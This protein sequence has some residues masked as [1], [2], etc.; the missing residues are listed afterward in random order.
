MTTKLTKQEFLALIANALPD[1]E[2]KQHII[3]EATRLIPSEFQRSQLAAIHNCRSIQRASAAYRALN[4]DIEKNSQLSIDTLVAWLIDDI[5]GISYAT[6]LEKN[7]SAIHKIA[8]LN[9]TINPDKVY[10]LTGEQIIELRI[11]SD[12]NPVLMG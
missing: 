3:A 8:W 10:T 1:D 11:Y 7:L 4:P 2:N 6:A 12:I 9:G 5:A